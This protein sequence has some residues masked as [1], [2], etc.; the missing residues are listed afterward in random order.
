MKP[1]VI[2]FAV[3]LISLV[4]TAQAATTVLEIQLGDAFAGT[5][6]TAGL[7]VPGTGTPL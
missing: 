6:E 3:A 1:G 2:V 5:I 4:P 7:A